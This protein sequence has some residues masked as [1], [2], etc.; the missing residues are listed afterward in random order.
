VPVPRLRGNLR[1]FPPF[2]PPYVT[3]TK[4]LQALVEDLYGVMTVADLAHVTYLSWDTV[5]SIVKK[6]LEKGY[7]H[8]R[9]KHLRR[10]SIDEIYLGR[11]KQFYTLV[12]DLD[13]GRIVW[14]AQGRGGDALRKF[15]RALRLSKAKIEAVAMDMSAA[16]WSAVA[17][18]LPNAA[19]VFD[20]FH[21]VKLVNEKLDDLRRDLVREA[22]GMMKQTVK[23]IRY[24]L[25]M[26]RENVQEEKLPRL[27]QAL[28]HNEPLFIG[29]LLK[30]ALGLLWEQPSYTRMN[31]FLHEWCSWALDSGIRQMVQLAKTLLTHA[32]GILSWWKHRINN[33]RMEGI[34]NKIKTLLRQTYGLRDER[35][36]VLRLFALHH[37]R[38]ELLG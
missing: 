6:R 25:L 28:K 34:N 21:I 11:R 20:R 15:W 12:I 9:L 16:Y 37:S 26:R 30:E 1:G 2:A 7:G 13:T 36:F 38:H 19:I 8:P 10:L 14:V 18:N 4:Q 3:Y 35:Y 32:R 17:E 29:Y 33:G 22:T 5:K 31:A 27:D 24:L 23:G